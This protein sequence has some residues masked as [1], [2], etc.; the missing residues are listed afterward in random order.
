M[1]QL[2]RLP[3]YEEGDIVRPT[4]VAGSNDG[5][6]PR[7]ADLTPEQLAELRGTKSRYVEAIKDWVAKGT[8]S[9]FALS[10]DEVR[11]RMR[12]PSE[13]V[14]LANAHFRLGLFLRTHGRA[15]EGD[16]HLAE[17]KRLRP[18]SW[19]FKRQAWNLEA[20]GDERSSGPDFWAAV[21]ALG[22]DPY[23]EPIDMPGMP[24]PPGW[25]GPRGQDGGREE[26]P[27][28]GS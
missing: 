22:D 15:E 1:G 5:F 13:E 20:P 7:T 28:P 8:A 4:E 19:N 11:A 9:E 23:Y 3:L 25:P 24:R 14:G 27:T 26:G 2:V 16:G 12:L 6:R 17:A 18:E 10:P 21:A